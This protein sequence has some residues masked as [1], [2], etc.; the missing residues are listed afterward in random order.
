MTH[1]RIV[2]LAALLAFAFPVVDGADVCDEPS[3]FRFVAELGLA[4]P[5]DGGWLVRVND[6]LTLYTHG[7]DPLPPPRADNNSTSL[8]FAPPVQP[9]C[10][11]NTA[12]EHHMQV[13]YSRPSNKP[14]RYATMAPQVRTMVREANGHL[15]N[16]GAEAAGVWTNYRV[17]CAN[18]DIDVKNAVLP[19]P[20]GSDSFG[21]IV[22]DLRNQGYASPLAKYWIWH[23]DAG[24]AAG[25]ANLFLNDSPGQNNPN[26]G[27]PM[28]AVTFGYGADV[29]MHENGHNL[30]AVQLTSPFSSRLGHC[31]D[32]NDV[33][34]YLERVGTTTAPLCLERNHFDCN[35]NDY[36]HPKAP[37]G[38]YLA[39]HWNIGA[40]YVRW[41]EFSDKA[42]LPTAPAL[43]GQVVGTSNVQ[44]SWSPP[45]DPGSGPVVEYRLYRGTTPNS[46]GLLATLPAT[47]A[48][49]GETVTGGAYYYR[50]SAANAQGEGN[51]SAEVRLTTARPPQPPLA[52]VATVGPGPD[53][54]T[55]AWLPPTSDEGS[56]VTNYRVYR[57]PD[58]RYPAFI[59]DAGTSTSF[60]DTPPSTYLWQYRVTAVSNAGE[61]YKSIPIL[62]AGG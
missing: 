4:C 51:P 60:V 28:Y 54:I 5:K 18:G 39:T 46:G 32:D 49:Y 15:R 12:G 31:N 8:G 10:V 26:N 57:A 2:L 40:R 58:L 17:A 9:F 22:N 24:E 53:Q 23:D 50:V 48:N 27:G 34:C 1:G 43:T 13:I 11:T 47:T 20:S 61:S 59:G 3:G 6:G 38:N 41:I 62:M 56:A 16:E 14:D 19:T 36:F 33:M 44:L 21:S 35:H 7:P 29:M 55:I 30:G 52:L 37:V 45:A 42:G 25:V